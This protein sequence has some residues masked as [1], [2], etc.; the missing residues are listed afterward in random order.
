MKVIFSKDALSSRLYFGGRDERNFSS[1][2]WKGQTSNQNCNLNFGDI[3]GDEVT[4]EA[5]FPN[6]C[7]ITE[8][9][10]NI[11]IH[12]N[13]TIELT[14]GADIGGIITR[15]YYDHFDV[16]CLRNRTV[17]QTLEGKSVNVGKR[18]IGFS[19]KSTFRFS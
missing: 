8:Y 5:D 14:F 6:G 4:L 10:D 13:Q 9:D 12:Y 7:G 16:S 3:I 15:K 18:K 11:Y 2:G 17:Q 19:E 1:I